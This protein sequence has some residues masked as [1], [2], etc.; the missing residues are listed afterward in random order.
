MDYTIPALYLVVSSTCILLSLFLVIAT[1]VLRV[2]VV[3]RRLG[4]YL[5]VSGFVSLFH[6]LFYLPPLNDY[7]RE[8]LILQRIFS[9]LGGFP[10]IGTIL[11]IK[12][13]ILKRHQIMIIFGLLAVLII[14]AGADLF[15]KLGLLF[16]D[17]PPRINAAPLYKILYIPFSFV[18]LGG[19]YFLVFRAALLMAGKYRRL[20]IILFAGLFSILPFAYR[21]YLII[22]VSKDPAAK[23]FTFNPAIALLFIFVFAFLVY[24]VKIQMK[25]KTQTAE[26]PAAY[27]ADSVSD[28]DTEAFGI[29]VKRIE[30]ERLYA[31]PGITLDGLAELTGQPRNRVSMLINRFFGRN[32]TSFINTYRVE[33]M[34][35]LLSDPLQRM[36]IMEIGWKVGFSSKSS[37]NRVF[38]GKT[39][40]SPKQYRK[41]AAGRTEDED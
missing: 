12:R 16:R 8:L 6:A 29:L 15:G 20:V 33:E 19:S 28:N 27:D 14:V 39:G 23:N 4:Y 35:R 9:L 13:D 7:P 34:K 26:K 5:L 31:D 36:T 32:F 30:Q 38:S 25:Y 17:P 11:A 40:V 24:F 1:S 22:L 2:N 10:L 18:A 37:L 21:D 3:F 41:Q